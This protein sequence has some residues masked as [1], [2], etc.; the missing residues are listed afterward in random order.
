M[1]S[2]V[3]INRQTLVSF[4][5]VQNAYDSIMTS[6][7]PVKEQET[8]ACGL[9]V[10][11]FATFEHSIS[12]LFYAYAQGKPSL[13]GQTAM[14]FVIPKDRSHAES[15]AKAGQAIIYWADSGRVIE[16]AEDWFDQGFILGAAL[17]THKNSIDKARL[18][19]NYIA[20]RSEE[21]WRKFQG[22][23]LSDVGPVP[24]V[25]PRPGEY[26]LR[27]QSRRKRKATFFELHVE[28]LF[29]TIRDACH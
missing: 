6:S 4:K 22:V 23:W 13:S 7:A 18:C 16:R 14:R 2:V 11:A 12:E 21:S 10:S 20:H 1:R 9:F 28:N 5:R 25:R 29:L 8:V 15:V 27:R 17:K 24:P 26:L 3:Q 19:R